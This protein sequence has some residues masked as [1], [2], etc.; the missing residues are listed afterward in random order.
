MPDLVRTY[1]ITVMPKY[2]ENL[3]QNSHIKPWYCLMYANKQEKLN[4][5]PAL[6]K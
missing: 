4:S 2:Y 5:P 6:R 1:N 3:L